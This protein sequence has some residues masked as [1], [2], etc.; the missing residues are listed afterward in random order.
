MSLGGQDD[1][2]IVIWDVNN[3]LALCGAYAS[4]E[5]AGNA[6]TIARTNIRDQCFITGG[7]GTLKVWHIDP[8]ARKVHGINIKVGK[9]RRCINCIAVDDKDTEAYCGTSSG[10]IIRTR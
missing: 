2:N 1:G 6:L 7:D 4:T 9:L 8:E 3:K 10:D 5:I